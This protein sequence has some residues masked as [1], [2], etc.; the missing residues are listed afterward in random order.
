[1][2]I[3]DLVNEV[4]AEVARLNDLDPD[5]AEELVWAAG[6]VVNLDADGK[7]LVTM[8]GETLALIWPE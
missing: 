6:D 3:P 7:R 1:M 4:A 8:D 2:L 5:L